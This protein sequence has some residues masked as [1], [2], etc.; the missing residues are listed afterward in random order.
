M[1][2]HSVYFQHWNDS[3]ISTLIKARRLLLAKNCHAK[4]RELTPRIYSQLRRVDRRLQKISRMEMV[5]HSM[6]SQHR[7]DSKISTLIKARQ[8]LLIYWIC[9]SKALCLTCQQEICEKN[10]FART[11]FCE[12]VFDRENHENFCLTKISRYTVTVVAV[13]GTWCIKTNTRTLFPVDT[14]SNKWPSVPSLELLFENFQHWYDAP[15]PLHFT[16]SFHII[17]DK[18]CNTLGTLPYGH[19]GKAAIYDIDLI[20][21]LGIITLLLVVL[22]FLNLVRQ[23]KGQKMQFCC[24]CQPEYTLPPPPELYCMEVPEIPWQLYIHL[25]TISGRTSIFPFK[26]FINFL[27]CGCLTYFISK[28]MSAFSMDGTLNK[29][30]S[31]VQCTPSPLWCYRQH[32]IVLY[33]L[34]FTFVKFGGQVKVKG[35]KVGWPKGHWHRR[36]TCNHMHKNT[37]QCL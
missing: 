21:R 5:I 19:V 31:V 24:A 36:N 7:N 20:Q 2:T 14:R 26:C 25:F 34:C 18:Q 8:L 15:R 27:F 6:Y 33:A 16:I 23:W 1:V 11:N 3:K 12:L 22:T 37:M 29:A 4:G 32:Q 17:G 13:C 30:A 28:L 35:S 9:G 10:F